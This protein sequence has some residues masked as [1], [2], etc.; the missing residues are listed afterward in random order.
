[1]TLGLAN[2]AFATL[3]LILLGTTA[4]V[5]AQCPTFWIQIGDLCYHK[6]DELMTYSEAAEYCSTLSTA[7]GAGTI[8]TFPR[9]DDFASFTGY[10]TLTAPTEGNYW[11]GATPDF[12][13]NWY[14]DTYEP[15]QLGVPFWAYTEGNDDGQ[16]CA[17]MDRRFWFQLMDDDCGTMKGV[18]CMAPAAASATRPEEKT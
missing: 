3:S 14:W 12:Q 15:L 6:N 17:A 11:V 5:Q 13:G 1:M 18:A 9:C 7:G 10:L 8:A 4:S 2:I 16:D